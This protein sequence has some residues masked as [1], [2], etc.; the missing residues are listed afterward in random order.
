MLPALAVTTPPVKCSGAADAMALP[1][2]RSLNEPI[3]CKFLQLEID[4]RRRVLH[5]QAQQWRTQ[6]G[7]LD[8]ARR[9]FYLAQG[10]R[11]H[12]LAAGGEA[13]QLVSIHI[14]T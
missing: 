12:A 9:G 6:G 1:A 3:G 8:A 13:R 14:N 2:P 5:W 4:L 7:A 10:N 11:I